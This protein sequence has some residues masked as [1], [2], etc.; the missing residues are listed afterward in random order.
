MEKESSYDSDEWP[1]GPYCDG[2]GEADNPQHCACCTVFLCNPLTQDGVAYVR[3]M[4][5]SREKAL[6]EAG[7][8]EGED[9]LFGAYREFYGIK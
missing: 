7:L 1:K 9:S 5:E 6:R 8:N 4:L 2:G 3:A